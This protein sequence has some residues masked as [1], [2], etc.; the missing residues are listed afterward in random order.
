MW[1]MRSGLFFSLQ[2][3]QLSPFQ[4]ARY[5]TLAAPGTKLMI[6]LNKKSVPKVFSAKIRN[7]KFFII[8][9]EFCI[10]KY[11]EDHSNLE[12][13]K[14]RVYTLVS[15]VKEPRF[16]LKNVCSEEI[17]HLNISPMN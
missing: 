8:F 3:G 13:F 11:R 9:S 14:D 15:S 4:F 1:K 5:R 12:K 7:V 2:K 6:F 16:G 10:A 17:L